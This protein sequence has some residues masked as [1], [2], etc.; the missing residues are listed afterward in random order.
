VAGLRR[1]RH[2]TRSD[3]GFTLLELMVALGILSVGL[4]S[5]LLMQLHAMRGGQSGRHGSQA[6][7]IARDQMERLHRMPWSDANLDDTEAALGPP[8][9][10]TAPA[11]RNTVV[12]SDTAETEENYTVQWRVDD[13]NPNLKAIDVRVV[14]TEENRPTRAFVVSSVRHN[15]P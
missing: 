12:Q 7:V 11:A 8:A 14:W 15:D 6:A 1:H 5:M 10:W 3:G 9:G 4:L 2:A 13:V